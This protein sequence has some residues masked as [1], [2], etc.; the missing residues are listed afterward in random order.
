MLRTPTLFF[1]Q[2]VCTRCS[3]HAVA[4]QKADTPNSLDTGPRLKPLSLSHAPTWHINHRDSET[5]PPH[6]K[7]Y[8]GVPCSAAAF[9]VC[10]LKPESV[11]PYEHMHVSVHRSQKKALDTMQQAVMSCLTCL[12]GT[13]FG[14]Q[15]LNHV[16]SPGISVCSKPECSWQ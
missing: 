1:T 7:P 16:S 15:K 10:F 13:N 2:E 5:F 4:E 8:C 14:P 9:D 6:G 12:L 3:A 11:C